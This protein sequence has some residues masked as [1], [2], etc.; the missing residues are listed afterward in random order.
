MRTTER[1]LGDSSVFVIAKEGLDNSSERKI[2]QIR[3]LSNGKLAV[4][5]TEN[6][7]LRKYD[8]FE[9]LSLTRDQTSQSCTQNLCFLFLCK[10][11]GLVLSKINQ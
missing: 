8:K 2:S 7:L 6:S 11:K 3:I 4:V 10:Q 1:L 5:V 9:T